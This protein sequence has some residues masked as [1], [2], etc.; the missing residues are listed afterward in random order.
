MRLVKGRNMLR[1]YSQ[2]E[3]SWEIAQPEGCATGA[4]RL[5]MVLGAG[6][7]GLAFATGI[8]V[9]GAVG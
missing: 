9:G 4:L 1:P 2:E 8:G 7:S 3:R 5:E 6:V